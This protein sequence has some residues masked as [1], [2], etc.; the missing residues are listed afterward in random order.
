MERRIY[1][2]II[3]LRSRV[4]YECVRRTRSPESETLYH[5]T[6]FDTASFISEGIEI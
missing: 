6:H 4:E 5:G 3:K 1:T 2:L